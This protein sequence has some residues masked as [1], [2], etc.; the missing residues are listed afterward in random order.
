MNQKLD[1]S[2]LTIEQL[3]AIAFSNITDFTS[4][5]G[6]IVRLKPLNEI[7][8]KKLIAIREISQIQGKTTLK[9]HDSVTAVRL[10]GEY[11]GLFSDFNMAIAALKKY[12][13]ELVQNPDNSWEVKED[14]PEVVTITE[15]VENTEIS[16]ALLK[17]TV[18]AIEKMMGEEI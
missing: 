8:P 4:F 2:K 9:L 7:D 16:E 14:A 10:L 12:G 5:N 17:N 3:E 15:T 18:K 11:L 1:L 6:C 13:I